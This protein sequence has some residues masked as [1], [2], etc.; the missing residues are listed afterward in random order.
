MPENPTSDWV[1]EL[2]AG[3]HEQEDATRR[4]HELLLRAAHFEVNRRRNSLDSA[5]DVDQLA[6]DAAHD[7]LMAVLAKLHTFRGDSRFTT[8]A[9]KFALLEAAVKV[10]RRSWRDREVSLEPEAWTRM[11]NLSEGPAGSAEAHELMGALQRAI[12]ET[13]TPHQRLVLVAVTIEGVPI[14]VLAER[15]D[16]TRG[17]VYKTLHD[18]RRKLRLR[19]AEQGF[20][21]EPTREEAAA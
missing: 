5:V 12:R 14:D 11:P 16:T 21:I 3:G 13:L 2:S 9:Y 20:D 6:A 17:A 1:A 15:I 18:A 7:A 8:W 10:R 4:L 19:L